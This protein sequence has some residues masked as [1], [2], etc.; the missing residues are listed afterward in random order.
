MEYALRGEETRQKA[1]GVLED[2]GSESC[3]VQSVITL[4]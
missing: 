3:L 4:T 2:Q 1:V